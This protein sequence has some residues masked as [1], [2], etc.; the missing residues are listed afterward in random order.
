MQNKI[1]ISSV[2]ASLLI[3]TNLQANSSKIS[4]VTVYSATK[5]EQS[6]KDVTSSVNVITKEEIQEKNFTTVNQALN[7]LSGVSIVS[8][9]G[10]GS[11]SSTFLRG[12]STKRV[13]VLI[14]GVTYKDPANSS[15]A[16]FQHLMINDIE[17]IEVIKGAQSGIWGADAS[18]GVINII[19]SKAKEGFSGNVNLE[20]GSYDTKKA[21]TVLS[22][23]AKKYDIRLSADKTK[24]TGFTSKLPYGKDRDDFENDAY[25]NT[26][27]NLTSNYYITENSKISFGIKNINFLSEYDTSSADD[28]NMRSNGETTLY[29]LGY[30]HKIKN[31]ELKVKYELSKFNRVEEGTVGSAWGENVLEFN[32][33]NQNIEISDE[34]TYMSNSFLLMGAGIKKDDVDYVLTDNSTNQRDSENKYIYLTNSNKFD[35]LILTQSLRYDKFDN[36]ENK[37]TGKLGVKYYFTKDLS[38]FANYGTA[39]NVPNIIDELNP[40]GT[41]NTNLKPEKTKGFDLGITYK[42]LTLTYFETKVEDLITWDSITSKNENIGGESK[43]KGLEL[44]YSNEVLNDTFITFNYTIQSAKDDEDKDLERRAKQ[45]Y[46]LSLDYHGLDKI[47]FNVNAQYIGDRVINDWTDGRVQTGNYAVVN[48]VINYEMNDNTRLYLKLDNIFDEDYNTVYGYAT[49]GRSAYVGL[50]YN[51]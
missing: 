4:D 30:S 17:R 7:S 46:K 18:A 16:S 15:G 40:W 19:T 39:Y 11:S 8:N 9:G 44:E 2:V 42:N 22:Y 29:N 34:F 21:S 25:D 35:N 10:L 33:E 43:F 6:I 31:H 28:S 37:T 5:T 45:L 13:L 1:C 50:R 38:T 3:A 24:T 26:T 20:Y 51:F 36:Y 27:V 14:D 49:A 32:G 47:H 48:G 41:T 12:L 23:G